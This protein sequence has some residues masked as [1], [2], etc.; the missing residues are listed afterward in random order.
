MKKN[1]SKVVSY[2]L[3]QFF[4]HIFM[5]MYLLCLFLNN[6]SSRNFKFLFRIQNDNTSV[7]VEVIVI[8]WKNYKTTSSSLSNLF[9][10][11]AQKFQFPFLLVLMKLKVLCKSLL[12]TLLVV[13]FLFPCSLHFVF[14]S[15]AFFLNMFK[16]LSFMALNVTPR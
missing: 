7:G 12:W 3:L 1:F 16:A 15:S 8:H 10:L 2:W 6:R 5:L 14:F 11:A 13:L 9:S 4:F